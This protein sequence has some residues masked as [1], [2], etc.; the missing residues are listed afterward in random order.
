[1]KKQLLPRA[2]GSATAVCLALV[3]SSCDQPAPGFGKS[4]TGGGDTAGKEKSA[5]SD[6]AG[7]GTA[8]A[9]PAAPAPKTTDAVTTPDPVKTVAATPPPPAPTPAPAPAVTPPP[10]APAP[11][12]PAA[13]ATAGGGTITI[14]PEMPKPLFAGTPLPENNPPPNLEDPK[15][16]PTLE[17]QVPEGVTLLSKGKPVTCSDAAPLGELS[18]ITDGDKNG[19]DGYFV[20]I[21]PGKHWVQLDLGESKEIHHIWVW[22]Y[23]KVAAVYKDVVVQISDD[24][25]FKTSTTV[26]NNDFDNSAEF[27][28]GTDKSWVETNHGRAMPVKGVKGRYVRLWS[29]GRNVDD[30]N[31]YIEVE[32]YGK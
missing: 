28:V 11:A 19:D 5:Y 29:N 13:P 12:P 26:F 6:I 8:T 1:M 4:E 21:L 31:H 14:K 3:L 16:K 7:S 18:W 27:G 20:D 22:H 2:A 24:P 10:P 25:E 30:T 23:H 9:A 32:V 15:T 17:V